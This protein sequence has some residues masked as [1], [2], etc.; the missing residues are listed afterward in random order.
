MSC[1]H[2]S[3]IRIATPWRP[4]THPAPANTWLPTV[5]TNYLGLLRHVSVEMIIREPSTIES[6]KLLPSVATP[7]SSDILGEYLE[8]HVIRASFRHC[9]VTLLVN[10]VIR[11]IL[12]VRLFIVNLLILLIFFILFILLT[13]AQLIKWDDS[14]KL[15]PSMRC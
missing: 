7:Q 13:L 10:L 14:D 4:A 6:E 1:R 9:I 5:A 15:M 8:R 3:W 2:R 12:F 11:I